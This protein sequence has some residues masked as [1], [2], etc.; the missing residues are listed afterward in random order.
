[1]KPGL[2]GPALAG[3][4]TLPLSLSLCLVSTHTGIYQ[5]LGGFVQNYRPFR[6]RCRL[7]QASQWYQYTADQ[8]PSPNTVPTPIFTYLINQ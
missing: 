3:Q 4:S 6:K 1:M 7:E 8:I 5:P 2:T